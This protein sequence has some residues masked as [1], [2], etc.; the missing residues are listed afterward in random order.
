M[1]EKKTDEKLKRA[2][3]FLE[4]ETQS[5]TAGLVLISMD[6]HQQPLFLVLERNDDDCA[7][8]GGRVNTGETLLEAA[9][10]ETREEVHGTGEID[11]PW[12]MESI[13]TKYYGK[14][15]LKQGVYFLARSELI[16]LT[17]GFNFSKGR[18]E[19]QHYRWLPYTEA[20]GMIKNR[21]QPILDW[22]YNKVIGDD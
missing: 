18:P 17:I 19:H 7:F 4:E 1:G 3:D 15:N 9:M 16:D 6:T 2:L 8:P 11:F 13:K 10:R 22:A 5:I 12:G 21:L 20:R 14:Q